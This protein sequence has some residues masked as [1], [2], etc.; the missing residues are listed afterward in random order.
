M[1]A[2]APPAAPPAAATARPWEANH[3]VQVM[4]PDCRETPA[5]LVEEFSSGDMV[6]G[7]CGLVLGDRIVDTRSEWRT[8]SNDDQGNDDPSRVGD[9]AN[10]FLNGSQLETSIS[11]TPGGAGRD[12]H[13]AQSK[14]TAQKNNNKTLLAAYK[15][16]GAFCDSMGLLKNV[17]DSAKQLFKRVDDGKSLK[18]KPQEAIVAGCIFIACRQERVPRTF[19]EIFALTKVPKKEIGRVF[20]QLEKIFHEQQ[21]SEEAELIA[22]GGDPSIVQSAS[23]L[24]SSYKTTSS[25]KAHDLMIR[26]CN[27][28]HLSQQ[29]TSIA[30]QLSNKAANLGTLAGRSPISSAAACIYL[31]SHLLKQPKSAKEISSVA[32]VSDGTIR[33][34]YKHLYN[35]REKL[36]DKAWYENGKG[37]LSA[38]PQS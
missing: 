33:N 17:S 29:C 31:V 30:Q 7:S 4:C 23:N 22:K 14:A 15:E 5:N 38:L 12:L 6:C 36:I 8:F 34:A 25:T 9:G 27:N 20:K 18:G 3:N 28:L 13:R 1:T 19:R 37:D 21:R 26:Y 2:V 16:I 32:G 10:P 35:D 24:N 11:Y